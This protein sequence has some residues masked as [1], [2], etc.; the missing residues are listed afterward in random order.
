MS[1]VDALAANATLDAAADATLTRA[2]V[3]MIAFVRFG[4]PGYYRLIAMTDPS[5]RAAI[6]AFTK[7]AQLT[8]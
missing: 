8:R 7:A 3:R 2:L 1:S 4:D 5:V 6:E